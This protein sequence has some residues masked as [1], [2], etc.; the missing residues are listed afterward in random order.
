MDVA[1]TIAV[2][3]VYILKI[4]QLGTVDVGNGLEWF[5]YLILPNFC[6]NKALQDVYSNYQYGTICR[7]I[8]TYVNRTTFCK[9][10]AASNSSNPC[11]PGD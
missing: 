10:M 3:A 11:C 4:P 6:F 7:S 8:D 1:G 9:L 2:L 5:F